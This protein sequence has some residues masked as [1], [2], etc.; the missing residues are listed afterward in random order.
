MNAKAHSDICLAAS[1]P[2]SKKKL[3]RKVGEALYGVV[4]KV[5][6]DCGPQATGQGIER[7]G[8]GTSCAL[9]I[10]H[11]FKPEL[12]PLLADGELRQQL[13]S[14]RSKYVCK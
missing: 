4:T 6:E 9:R 3:R 13:Q 12:L 5:I 11:P 8:G 10:S 14:I 2:D 1:G 7:S